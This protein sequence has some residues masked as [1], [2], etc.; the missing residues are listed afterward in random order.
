MRHVRAI[1]CDQAD[2]TARACTRTG[3]IKSRP[4]RVVGLTTW[5]KRPSDT[6][7]TFA[8][9][10]HARFCAASLHFCRTRATH[11]VINFGASFCVEFSAVYGCLRW[12]T[13]P[14]HCA[15]QAPFLENPEP[16]EHHGEFPGK[17]RPL[18]ESCGTRLK[19][20]FLSEFFKFCKIWK[21][22]HFF[23]VFDCLKKGQ[24]FFRVCKKVGYFFKM[25]TWIP[26]FFYAPESREIW[27]FREISPFFTKI[28][29][30]CVFCI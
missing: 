25:W 3:C 5:G 12:F 18:A 6:F 24:N 1:K 21:N 27:N 2:I 29:N 9:R 16:F 4:Y 30:E 10:D 17:W 8:S 7:V 20:R 11:F 23:R 28:W 22:L 13:D 14:Y 19:N 26:P 15:P